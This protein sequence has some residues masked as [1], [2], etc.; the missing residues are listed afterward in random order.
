MKRSS[1][2]LTIALSIAPFLP[3]PGQTIGGGRASE[4][5]WAVVDFKLLDKK[6]VDAN[7]RRKLDSLAAERQAQC[8]TYEFGSRAGKKAAGDEPYIWMA[9]G[10]FAPLEKRRYG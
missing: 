6:E 1:V 4:S 3:C 7:W 5:R 2:L 10:A 9:L 8:K